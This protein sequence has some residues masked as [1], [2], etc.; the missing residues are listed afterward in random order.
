MSHVNA[1]RVV[2]LISLINTVDV[3]RAMQKCQS[4]RTF[5]GQYQAT[6][7]GPSVRM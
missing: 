5:G 2:N 7:I 4:D 3:L 1:V 6:L